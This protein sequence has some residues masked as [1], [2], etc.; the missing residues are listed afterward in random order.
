MTR[1]DGWWE[2]DGGG[3]AGSLTGVWVWVC[4]LVGWDVVGAVGWAG[5]VFLVGVAQPDG[6][7]CSRADTRVFVSRIHF[8]A[9]INSALM[10]VFCVVMVSMLIFRVVRS[11]CSFDW[12]SRAVWRGSWVIGVTM[13][14]R[15]LRICGFRASFNASRC[16]RE[17]TILLASARRW[18]RCLI[19]VSTGMMWKL[20]ESGNVLS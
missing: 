12:F 4:C 16:W 14:L 8:I 10:L 15:T 7:G 2:L 11:D 3:G 20:I 6:G 17:V 18:M 5:V 19:C 13:L 1:R 9:I